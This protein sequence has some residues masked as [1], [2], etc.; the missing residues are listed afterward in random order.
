MK[1]KG[2]T[3]LEAIIAMAVMTFAIG[4]V[5]YGFL[6][7]AN[8]FTE[9]M[10][11]TDVGFETNKALE[12]MTTEMRNTLEIVSSGDTD[13]TFWHKDL[14]QNNSREANETISY[15]WNGTIGGDLIKTTDGTP[16][17]IAKGVNAFSL[18]YDSSSEATLIDISI[19]IFANN[20]IGTLESSVQCRNL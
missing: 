17:I 11:E 12:Q 8:I 3:L 14:N 5:F 13:I 7:V 19:T 1:N 6:A 9:E 15:S 10:A 20:E 18:S 16:V 4:I 2:F